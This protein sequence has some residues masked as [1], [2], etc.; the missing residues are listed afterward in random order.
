MSINITYKKKD[1]SL[2][3]QEQ[4]LGFTDRMK[5][6]NRLDAVVASGCGKRCLNNFKDDN[7]NSNEV[8]CITNCA[9]RYYDVLDLGEGLYDKFSNK[10]FDVSNLLKG[11]FSNVANHI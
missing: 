10:S 1:P 9:L 6:Y 7:L 5:N 11:D 2:K 8:I 3:L 4:L